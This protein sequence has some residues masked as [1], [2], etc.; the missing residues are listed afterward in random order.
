R[1]I[2]GHLGSAPSDLREGRVSGD[3]GNDPQPPVRGAML[4]FLP[5]HRG[6]ELR[7]SVVPLDRLSGGRDH[8]R[9][10]DRVDQSGARRAG[11]HAH[12]P[13]IAGMT[14]TSS[15]SWTGAAKPPRKRT[16]SSFR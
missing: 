10:P 7:W 2:D 6:P 1:A 5:A 3:R 8:V 13:A 11:A 9:R 16:S 15:P 14:V 12:P 4:V